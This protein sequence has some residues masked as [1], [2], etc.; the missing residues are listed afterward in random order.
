MSK[1]PHLNKIKIQPQI[2]V[3]VILLLIN[4]LFITTRYYLFFPYRLLFVQILTLVLAIMNFVNNGFSKNNKSKLPDVI[5]FI[6]IIWSFSRTYFSGVIYHDFEVLQYQVSSIIL[7]FLISR[8]RINKREK[9][10][11]S[12]AIV[13]SFVFSIIPG[14]IFQWITKQNYF[15]LSLNWANANYYASYLLVS[16]SFIYYLLK[17][18]KRKRKNFYLII[19]ILAIIFLLW[20]Q[21]R[22]G[23]LTFFVVTFLYIVFKQKKVRKKWII[24]SMILIILIFTGLFLAFKQIRPQTIIF[25]QRIYQS[26]TE[27]I[28]DFWIVGSGTG[29]FIHCFPK[30]RLPD[31]Q[32]LGQEDIISHAHNE[33]LEIWTET[34]IVGLILFLTFIILILKIVLKKIKNNSNKNEMFLTAS[35]LSFS[36]LL[37][38]NLFSIT[39]RISSIYVYLFIF[40]GL[41]NGEIDFTKDEK[42]KNKTKN[43]IF[44]PI[45]LILI[46]LILLNI[47]NIIGLTY[48]QKARDKYSI[49]TRTQMLNSIRYCKKAEKYIPYKT[50]LLYYL[51]F[52]N[53]FAKNYSEADNYFTNLLEIS[54]YYPQAH[55]WKGYIYSLSRNWDKAIVEYEIELNYNQY[56][57]IYYNT[58]IAYQFNGD[59]KNS[60]KYY[61]I[62][63]EKIEEKTKKDIVSTKSEI[64]EKELKNIKYALQNLED[65]YKNNSKKLNVIMKLKNEIFSNLNSINN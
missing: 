49:S 55:F 5:I 36:F 60:L 39:L 45:I 6:F 65:Y 29:S 44:L 64:I 10:I 18:S 62:Y 23:L 37:F 35:L 58:A 63:L 4:S 56:P 51:G 50:D 24:I 33:F 32:L 27:Y 15:R 1:I 20:T 43:I 12:L 28:K 57:K 61:Q 48:F 31:Y 21:S 46:F 52:M 2:Y 7:Y 3:L 13:F 16:I 47:K 19:L 14:F 42:A 8:L 25:R 26:V 40:A 54:P 11:L 38:H 22:G 9:Q 53:V 59:K 34:G 41:L 17:S 30:Y